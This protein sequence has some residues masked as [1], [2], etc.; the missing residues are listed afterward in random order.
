M[1]RTVR[2][3]TGAI[4]VAAGRGERLGS[5]KQFLVV[6]SSR[7]VDHAVAA[8]SATCDEVVVV[9]PANQGWDGAAVTSCVAGGKTRAESVRAGLA[10]LSAD[11]EIIVVHDAARPLATPELFS[12]VIDVVHS[13]ADAAVPAVLI[14]DTIK[15]V[16]SDRVVET[17]DRSGLVATQTPQ[18][19]RSSVLRAAHE[20]SPEATDD[21][22]LVEA[23]GGRVVVVTGDARNLKVTTLA[24]V[25]IV[26]ALLGEASR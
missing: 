8:A 17:V 10:A 5:P 2:E 9:L 21:A 14:T 3:R 16:Q 12:L 13:G 18:A 1:E 22:A 20:N 19:F 15:R 23:A 11:V 26:E 7:L 24:D 4:V 6:G 25:A